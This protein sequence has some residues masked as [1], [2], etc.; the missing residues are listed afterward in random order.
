M[1]EIEIR[2]VG[3]YKAVLVGSETAKVDLGLLDES[4]QAQAA[5]VFLKAAEELGGEA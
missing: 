4:E 3:Q 2:R 1:I 5:E